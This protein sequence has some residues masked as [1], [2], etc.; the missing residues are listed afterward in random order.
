MKG[1]NTKQK[2]FAYR[3]FKRH[4]KSL[5]FMNLVFMRHSQGIWLPYFPSLKY[6]GPSLYKVE[7]ILTSQE[8]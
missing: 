6:S 7:L 3:I 1:V 2:T 4:A 5:Y 8:A